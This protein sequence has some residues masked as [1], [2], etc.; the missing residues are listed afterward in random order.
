MTIVESDQKKGH[1][2][3]SPFRGRPGPRSVKPS[4]SRRAVA[5]THCSSPNGRPRSTHSL[6]HANRTAQG[7]D[8]LAPSSSADALRAK[9]PRQAQHRALGFEP[10]ATTRSSSLWKMRIRPLPR[11]STWQVIPPSIAR[12]VRGIVPDYHKPPTASITVMSLHDHARH[13][14]VVN[15][16]WTTTG[17]AHKGTPCRDWIS[18]FLI[19]VMALFSCLDVS[20][21]CCSC[22]SWHA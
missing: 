15:C 10:V 12:A 14:P 20:A 3:F 17:A 22:S 7:W 8:S 1:H 4:P 5:A 2:W 21:G 19:S 6:K 18:S 9:G 11:S 16:S 13:P